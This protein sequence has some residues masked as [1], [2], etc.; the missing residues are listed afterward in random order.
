MNG[1]DPSEYINIMAKH[2][3]IVLMDFTRNVADAVFLQERQNMIAIL[4]G[5]DT[6]QYIEFNVN[7][8]I[9]KRS[10]NYRHSLPHCG[11]LQ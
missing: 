1:Y 7:F 9:K 3:D 6:Q 2:K 10:Q 5:L 8:I 4:E 11:Y